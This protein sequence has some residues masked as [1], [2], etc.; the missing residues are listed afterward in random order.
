MKRN[1][2]ILGISILLT[3]LTISGCS[4]TNEGSVQTIEAYLQAFIEKN[5][6]QMINFSCGIWEEQAVMEL[7]AF[8]TVEIELAGVSCQETEN[9]GE[10][11][12]VICEGEILATY[13]EEKQS[14]PLSG[15]TYSVL[16]EGGEWRMCGYQ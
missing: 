16:K 5:K 12:L 9:T 15:R 8:Q 4:S 3:L 14:F 10:S 2:L 6:D 11:A 1:L 13:N 7:D